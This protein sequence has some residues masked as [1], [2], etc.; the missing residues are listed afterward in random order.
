M[1]NEKFVEELYMKAFTK[2][3]IEEFRLELESLRKK[4]ANLSRTEIAEIAYMETKRRVNE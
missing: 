1:T 4:H 3:F 2:G